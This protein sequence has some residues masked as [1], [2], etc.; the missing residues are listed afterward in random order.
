MLDSGAYSAW[1]SGVVID[2]DALCQEANNEYWNEVVALD[3]IGDPLAS[4]RNA[5]DMKRRGLTGIVPVFHY[6]DPWEVLAEYKHQFKRVG[7]ASG[8]G[9]KGKERVKWTEQCF[10]RAYPCMFHSFGWVSEKILLSFPFFSADSAS[11]QW[12]MR[13]GYINSVHE[14]GEQ[15]K[16]KSRSSLRFPKVS[17]V[18]E[19][20]LDL[21]SE[22]AFYVERAEKVADRWRSEFRRHFP[23]EV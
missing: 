21:R 16:R 20:A 15:G 22:V 11:W 17:E 23:D 10:S 13:F 2:L 8:H 14:W 6:G 18:G 5:L 9:V 19:Q 1:N 4:L 3:V 12:A 7:L